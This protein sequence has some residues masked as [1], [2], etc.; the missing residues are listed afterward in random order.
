M[1]DEPIPPIAHLCS[2]I[3]AQ[4]HVVSVQITLTSYG[5]K[6][7]VLLK[8]TERMPVEDAPP[9]L[10]FTVFM[11]PTEWENVLNVDLVIEKVWFAD[12]TVW[13]R[14]TAAVIEYE[15]N[16]LPSGRKL[17]QLRFVAGEDAVGYPQMQ[18][19]A[20]IC[21][22]GRA[23]DLKSERC[24]RCKR[25][26]DTVFASC[27][28]ENVDSII[29]AHEQKLKTVAQSAREEA[30]RVAEKQETIRRKAVKKRRF[31]W[32]SVLSVL[33]V[34][35]LLSGVFL[36]GLP[37]WR[38]YQASTALADGEY[39]T[40]RD[41]FAQLGSFRDAEAMVSEA[42][43][44]KAGSLVE[45]NDLTAAAA[46]YMSLGDYKDSGDQLLLIRYKIAQSTFSTG[47]YETA[48]ALFGEIATY[49]D[50]A[51]MRDEALY[52]QASALFDAGNAEDARTIFA[53]LGAYRDSTDRVAVCDYQ[54]GLNALDAGNYELAVDKL[55]AVQ[56]TQDAAVK[57]QEAYYLWGM[58]QQ[59]A[60]SYEEAGKL[61]LKAGDYEDAAY[62]ANGS[63]YFLANEYYNDQDYLKAADLFESVI[64]YLDSETRNWD[65]VY[66]AGAVGG[67][68]G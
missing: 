8:Q 22:C 61:F 9:G 62:R 39:E 14:G 17:D 33:L 66:Q 23:N 47:D 40:A 32:T 58:E 21:V 34:A 20:W 55:E 64:P 37:A 19:Q 12:A 1:P 29:A 38:Y 67:A 3:S 48:A 49:Q 16:A 59:D 4:K 60:G 27:T 35:A 51:E 52:Q 41:S 57:L 42:D 15:P 26:R 11:V 54:I 10:P 44:R 63:L 24:C 2:T 43:Y 6:E 31:V 56:G 68:A 30:N 53:D 5:P 7:F 65:S 36:W 18:A 13:R 28:P 50:S 46:L 25:G 45:Q